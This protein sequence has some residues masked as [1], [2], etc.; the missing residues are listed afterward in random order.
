MAGVD[1][2]SVL[3]LSS[4]AAP[5]DANAVALMFALPSPWKMARVVDVYSLPVGVLKTS[6]IQFDPS[7]DGCTL[8]PIACGVPPVGVSRPDTI[9]YSTAASTTVIATI[10]MVA[11]TG[12]TAA[13]SLRMMLFMVLSSCGLRRHSFEG[14]T[15]AQKRIT[16]KNRIEERARRGT[17]RR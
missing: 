12:D 1:C 3:L 4:L 2:E 16:R 7:D 17:D 15:G 6:T 13:S 9:T 10:R 8:T 11:I 5:S 14:V